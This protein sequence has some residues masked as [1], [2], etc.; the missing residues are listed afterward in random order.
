[1]HGGVLTRTAHSMA[2]WQDLK[3][4]FPDFWIQ[5]EGA[6][7]VICDS[8]KV[9]TLW[10]TLEIAQDAK[11]MNCSRNCKRHETPH[12]GLKLREAVAPPKAK[13]AG[14]SGGFRRWVDSE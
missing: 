2:T 5:G 3:A 10:P 8:A 1:M 6:F 13:A 12:R 9:I 11:H 14:L 4:H 7:A